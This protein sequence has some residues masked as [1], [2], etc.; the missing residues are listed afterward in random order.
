VRVN[1]ALRTI[2]TA[3]LF[4]F[5]AKTNVVRLPAC[6]GPEPLRCGALLLDAPWRKND[7]LIARWQRSA[8]RCNVSEMVTPAKGKSWG[9]DRLWKPRNLRFARYPRLL[10]V[11]PLAFAITL[12]S[13]GDPPAGPNPASPERKLLLGQ[14]LSSWT[15]CYGP[16]KS[17]NGKNAVFQ[18][19]DGTAYVIVGN[20]GLTECASLVA[21]IA[22][23]NQ[24]VAVV[25]EVCQSL[26]VSYKD[27]ADG[28]KGKF[29]R[30]ESK[31]GT[32]RAAITANPPELVIVVQSKAFGTTNNSPMTAALWK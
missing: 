17:D 23:L 28:P 1:G 4:A 13:Y 25:T 5:L 26:G 11:A 16:P 30:Y 19:R 22:D 27:D 20:S 21:N 14:P 7:Q 10:L 6:V 2:S 18:T 32:M 9:R 15:T 8:D 12:N 3:G 31:D 24:L 29:H